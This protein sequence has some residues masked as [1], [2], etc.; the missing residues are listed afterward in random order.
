MGLL[1]FIG[2]RKYFGLDQPLTKLK[3]PFTGS[4]QQFAESQAWKYYDQQMRRPRNRMS[5]YRDYDRM[6]QYELVASAL[7]LYAEE[8]AKYD[9]E[10][11]ATIWVEA[12]NADI[13]RIAH[14]LFDRLGMEEIS[15]GI[16]RKMCKYGDNFEAITFNSETGDIINLQ[17]PPPVNLIRVQKHGKLL[18]F[19]PLRNEKQ[20]QLDTSTKADTTKWKPWEIIHFRMPSRER[21][22]LY[23]DSILY[24]AASA[25]EQ[26]KMVEDSLVV[27]RMTKA[28]DR[29]IYYIDVGNSTPE[30]A[31]DIVNRWKKAIKKREHINQGSGDYRNQWNP[32]SIDA[33]IFWP[34]REGSQSRVE[35]LPGSPNISDIVDIEYMRNKLFGALRIPKGFMGFEEDAGG[36]L[37]GES[38]LSSQSVRFASTI[39]AIRKAFLTGIRRLVAIQLVYKG[40][41]PEDPKNNFKIGMAPISYLDELMRSKI[42]QLRMDMLQ[43][44]VNVGVQIE[45]I[46]QKRWVTWSLKNFLRLSDDD[47]AMFMGNLP[48]IEGPGKVTPRDADKLIQLVQS[49]PKHIDA[50]METFL[51]GKIKA[52]SVEPYPDNWEYNP[53]PPMKK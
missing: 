5:R 19:R 28:T 10:H 32:Q 2:V 36:A 53:L 49:D 33:D 21:D 20:Q 24:P 17:S 46:D 14:Q 4:P 16:I 30:E 35:K 15:T 31:Y 38:T 34:I 44:A 48:D 45:Q 27:Y 42:Y 51:L 50:L 1:D 47:V 29:T 9:L 39:K 7:D 37:S 43:T 52:Q 22:A 23:G 18:G 41:D 8:C 12:N 26:L 3:D 6:D 11:D 40:I 25:W 13:V